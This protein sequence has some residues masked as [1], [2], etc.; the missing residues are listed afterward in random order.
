[1][2]R[3]SKAARLV[4]Q[5]DEV[6]GPPGHAE[7]EEI[8]SLY[9]STN[10]GMRAFVVMGFRLLE[11]KARLPH[12]GY[13]AWMQKNLPQLSSRHLHRSRQVAE[14]IALRLGWDGSNLPRVSNLDEMPAEVEALYAGGRP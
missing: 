6:S 3:Q 12:G 5:P 10:R 13:M 7:A 8:R 4:I 1:M 14:G 9:E 2:S 11:I